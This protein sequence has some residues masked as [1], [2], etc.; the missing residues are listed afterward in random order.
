[1]SAAVTDRLVQQ[2][3]ALLLPEARVGAPLK[4]LASRLREVANSIELLGE[5]VAAGGMPGA[6]LFINYHLSRRPSN[7]YLITFVRKS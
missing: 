7:G 2:L 4:L 3:A 6:R 1:M 5:E